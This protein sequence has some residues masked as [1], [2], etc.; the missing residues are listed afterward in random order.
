MHPARP[1]L[2]FACSRREVSGR[3]LWGWAR[4]RFGTPSRFFGRFMVWNYCPLAFLEEGGRN[5]TPDRLPATERERLFAP[6]DEALRALVARIEPLLVVG[7]GA[8]AARRAR[9][10]LGPEAA[11]GQVLHPSPASPAA[12]RGWTAAMDRALASLGIDVPAAGP[13]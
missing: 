7:V 3:R 12:N 13:R 1:V 11:V 6:C 5:R 4:E 9:A 8:F 10:A 2:G